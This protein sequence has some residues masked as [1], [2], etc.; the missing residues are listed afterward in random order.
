M[1][2]INDTKTVDTIEQCDALLQ[3]ARIYRAK[4]VGYSSNNS[5][6][7]RVHAYINRLLD[8][9]ILLCLITNGDMEGLFNRSE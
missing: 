9:R 3:G 7:E 4:L 1:I 5:A 2:D 8:R 6:L